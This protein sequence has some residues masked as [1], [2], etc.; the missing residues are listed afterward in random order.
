MC[1]RYVS[2]QKRENLEKVFGAKMGNFSDYKPSFN[3]SV[4]NYAPVITSEKPKEIQLF[5]FGLN[6]AWVKKPRFI[7]NAR[8]EGE[9]NLK[10]EMEYFGIKGILTDA[11]FS[12]PLRS[13]RCLVLADAY[14]ESSLQFGYKKPYAV[15]LKKSRRPFAFAGIWD[16]WKNPE[17]NEEINSFSIITAPA[18]ELV[19]RIPNDRMPVILPKGKE[20]A[21]LNEEKGISEILRLLRTYPSYMM[22]AY[23][24]TEQFK[25]TSVDGRW[26]LEP[27]GRRIDSQ[28][29]A[30]IYENA[31]LQANRK[32]S[33][34]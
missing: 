32:Y 29:G 5:R 17:T 27:K 15:Y 16:T 34:S 28:F 9:Y 19:R 13:Q 30:P 24:V 3:I 21:W 22:N 23:P 1:G 26:L 7:Y 31:D 33:Y 25:D 8:A 4:G 20:S 11:N 14:I 18:N 2:V 12:K 10:N 6:P